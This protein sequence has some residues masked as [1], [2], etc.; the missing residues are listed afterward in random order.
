MKGTVKVLKEGFG[1][2]KTDEAEGDVFFH[3]SELK[4][5]QFDDL[6]EGVTVLEFEM[7]EGRNG[8]K[9]AVNVMLAED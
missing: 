5:V 9:Q 8:K 7:G 1:F 2:I 3:V 6:E 4:G